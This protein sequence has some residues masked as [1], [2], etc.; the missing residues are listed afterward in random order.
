MRRSLNFY[1]LYASQDRDYATELEKHLEPLQ[2]QKSITI[3]SQEKVVAGQDLEEEIK[4]H[5]NDAD[6]ILPLLSTDFIV[7]ECY[8]Y[9]NA[10]QIFFKYKQGRVVLLPIYVRSVYLEPTPFFRMKKLPNDS[11]PISKW[12][13]KDEA[14]EQVVLGI[15]NA[16]KDVWIPDSTYAL[17]DKEQKAIVKLIDKKTPTFLTK[18]VHVS[19]LRLSLCVIT[20][21]VVILAIMNIPLF[22][23]SHFLAPTA[24]TSIHSETS[25]AQI[26]SLSSITPSAG[27]KSTPLEASTVEIKN[28]VQS[29]PGSGS[30]ATPVQP[31]ATPTP[32]TLDPMQMYRD[33]T[34]K[35]PT[36]TDNL[37]DG[38]AWTWGNG[39]P[40]YG[41]CGFSGKFHATVTGTE[42]FVSCYAS[43]GPWVNIVYQ[44]QVSI[45]S[46]DA[47][48]LAVNYHPRT[49]DPIVSYDGFL[50]CRDTS[51]SDCTPGDVW[52]TRVSGNGGCELQGSNDC[53]Q[54]Y[55]VVRTYPGATNILTAIILHQMIYLYINA[56]FIKSSPLSD[57]TGGDVGVV[58]YS[59]NTSG[60]TDAVF[61]D[62][63]IWLI[64]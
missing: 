8:A 39:V 5:L 31:V 60:G 13:D 57:S 50:F 22:S 58:A 55:P 38:S 14:F 49:S 62:A 9:L 1:I 18:N 3:W 47:A 16:L 59:N 32:S 10:P 33:Y 4:E 46:G 40:G 41:N 26:G 29:M 15:R 37:L 64:S 53:K 34:S 27:T 51:I 23:I 45:Q 2:L 56:T 30:I 44:V 35:P 17:Q 63:K 61:S 7:S 12:D 42:T 48:G 36:Q 28:T 54:T 6:V 11:L 21:V 24:E 52:L 19:L 25:T 43:N 20:I